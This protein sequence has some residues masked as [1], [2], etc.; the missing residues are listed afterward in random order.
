L[1]ES[2]DREYQESLERDRLVEEEREKK[3][4]EKRE[5]EERIFREQQEGAQ[6]ME[7]AI[8]RREALLVELESHY[9]DPNLPHS[10]CCHIV[11]KLPDGTRIEQKFQHATSINRLYDWVFTKA[12]NIDGEDCFLL[13]TSYPSVKLSREDERDL[14]QAGLVPNA[15]LLCSI[16]DPD[17]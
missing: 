11:V 4:Q 12:T 13:A 1:R 14:E 3:E 7:K 8:A 17:D 5:E 15:V 6:R 2:Q 16:V 10:K 9:Y